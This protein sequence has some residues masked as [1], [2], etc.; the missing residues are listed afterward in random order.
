MHSRL[1]TDSIAKKCIYIKFRHFTV[2]VLQLHDNTKL[3]IFTVKPQKEFTF[4]FHCGF[5]IKTFPPK[6]EY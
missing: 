3:Q 2:L 6:K 4:A 5:K 1:I